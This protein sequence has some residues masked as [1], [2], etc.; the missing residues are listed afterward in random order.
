MV[1]CNDLYILISG[2]NCE[3][4]YYNK[5]D[6]LIKEYSD[7]E[8]KINFVFYDMYNFNYHSKE[9]KEKRKDAQ[10]RKDVIDSYKRCIVTNKPLKICEVAHIFPYKLSAQNEMYDINNGLLLCREL[11]TLFDSNDKEFIINPKTKQ[12]ELS[13]CIMNDESLKEYHKY[14]NIQLNL[15]DANIYYLNKKYLV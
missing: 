14:N 4:E 15:N 6:E 11:H 13:D 8:D 2:L 9:E 10:F 1:T 12:I 3:E 5:Y 7:S